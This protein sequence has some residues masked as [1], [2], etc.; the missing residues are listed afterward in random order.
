MSQKL[1]ISLTLNE[2]IV[3]KIDSI[4]D[5]YEMKNR[6]DAI[7]KILNAYFNKQKLKQAIILC[8]GRGNKHANQT[9][10]IPESMTLVQ[11]T[12]IL[13][14]IIL[15]LKNEG[16]TEIILAVG[17]K[18]ETI[19]NYFGNGQKYGININY[20][21]E[22]EPQGTAG[23][24]LQAKDMITNTFLILNGDVISKIPID[25]MLKMHR[26]TN[27]QATMA[28]T[29]SENPQNYGVAQLRGNKIT[30]FV[31]KPTKKDAMTKLINAGTYI[32]EPSI[33]E[34]I[35]DMKNKNPDKKLM[36]EDMFD[37]ISK[38]DLLAGYIY[39]GIWLDINKK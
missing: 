21:I 35:A 22:K 17:Y 7:E 18:H 13:E 26:Q 11:N 29:T 15:H 10:D 2:D 24:I 12:P 6:S 5:G 34:L 19:V 4:T 38:Q 27:S 37:I 20:M 23:A 32:A 30:G 1:R 28:I 39:D 16:I 36:L 25:D 8:G 14:H 9:Q 3:N 31:E 33:F